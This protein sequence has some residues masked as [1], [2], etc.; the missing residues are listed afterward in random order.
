MNSLRGC[1]GSI[2]LLFYSALLGSAAPIEMTAIDWQLWQNLPIQN[3]GRHKPLDTLAAETLL[4]TSNHV[5]VVDSNS[6][7][8]PSPVALYLTMLFEWSG[9][10]HKQIDQLL[11]TPDAVPQYSFFHHADR[12]DKT[13]LLRI[14]HPDL[15]KMIGLPE[16][17]KFIAP[18]VLATTSVIDART[19]KSIPFPT[20]GRT[21]LKLKDSGKS[22]SR[23]E[24]QG[25]RL[26]QRLEVYQTERM[27]L[28]LGIVPNTKA[29]IS[30]WLSISELL[31]TKFDDTTDPHG[32][33]RRAQ[34]LFWAARSAFR[35]GDTATF[36]HVSREFRDAV[37]K[38][39]S[40]TPEQP[41]QS[42]IDVEVAYN[43]WRPFRYA[44]MLMLIATA[45]MLLHLSSGWRTF[46]WCGVGAYSLGMV[47]MLVGFS[48]RAIVSGRPP[49][50]N[51]Y[52]TVIYVG[53]G[54]A[55]LGIVLGTQYRQKY[56]LSAAAAISTVTLV[57]ADICPAILDA[58]VRPLESVLRNNFWLGTHVMTIGL[59]YAAFALALGIANI[60]LGY[61]TFR[62]IN[63]ETIQALSRFTYRAI[64]VGVLLLTAGIVLGGIWADYAW[65]RFWGW[66]PK[67][68]WALVALL[69]YLAV[70]HAR[71]SGA[72]GHRGLA[73]LSI[74]CFSLVIMAWYGVNFVLGTGLH[75]YGFGDG[76]Q[77]YVYL[78][79]FAQ[80][81]YVGVALYRSR[82]DESQ[83]PGTAADTH[84]LI[85]LS[86][87]S[88]RLGS[89]SSR[90]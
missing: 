26:A 74:A 27:G 77:G 44:W 29:D 23:V 64:Q 71:I 80:W 76:G 7:Q 38:I 4:F 61:Y 73:V 30:T 32:N 16:Q 24:E 54:V 8:K 83:G 34:R 2:V 25:L 66:D 39:S 82:L 12:W 22:L 68:V 21:L 46:I 67:E 81:S 13:P 53:S 86:A 52:E 88:N 47:S 5:P 14:D 87:S 19:Q 60:T 70:L 37:Q 9:W 65:G 11:L 28:G 3:G 59:S 17:V 35:S 56:V 31:L 50:T 90:I 41:R 40:G 51:M 18:D 89:I 62:S 10:D 58:S 63:S 33:F 45:G 79:I 84:T 49:V 42:K 36:N 55:S 15:K 6:G 48:M 85:C 20:W 75:S 78:A 57:L 72:V 1:T 43:H 69:G